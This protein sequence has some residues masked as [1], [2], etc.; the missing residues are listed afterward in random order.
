MH[1]TATSC[2]A[3]PALVFLKVVSRF[4][5]VRRRTTDFTAWRSI[6][7]LVSRRTHV[8]RQRLA[9]STCLTSRYPTPSSPAPWHGE[10]CVCSAKAIV[11]LGV[12]SRVSEEGL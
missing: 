12:R 11:H 1:S 4:G 8:G 7:R 6:S 3:E 9:R 2:S 10:C 5:F